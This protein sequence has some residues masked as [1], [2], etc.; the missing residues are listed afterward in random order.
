MEVING[1]C[2]IV[3]LLIVVIFINDYFNMKSDIE[4]MEKKIGEISNSNSSIN[5]SNDSDSRNSSSCNTDA[6]CKKK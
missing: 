4:R 2:N 5:G 1:I 6:D 3:I